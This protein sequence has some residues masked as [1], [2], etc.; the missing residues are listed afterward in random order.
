M[1]TVFKMITTSEN[2]DCIHWLA[3]NCPGKFSVIP[4]STPG[5]MEIGLYEESDAVLFALK[6]VKE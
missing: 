3:Y 4:S 2:I 6:W 5:V 1:T